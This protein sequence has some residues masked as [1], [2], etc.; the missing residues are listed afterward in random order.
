MS[1]DPAGGFRGEHEPVRFLSGNG[2]TMQ[3]IA[4]DTRPLQDLVSCAR[5]HQ[6]LPERGVPLY[7]P[8]LLQK[9]GTNSPSGLAEEFGD[10][11]DAE[12][13]SGTETRR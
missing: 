9:I 4:A 8:S 5:H 10:V 3:A 1:D 6:H 7:V 2:R 13:G 12:A 11:E